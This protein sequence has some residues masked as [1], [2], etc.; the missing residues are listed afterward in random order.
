MAACPCCGQP[1]ETGRLIVGMTGCFVYR[2]GEMARLNPQ[3]AALAHVLNE[4][5]GELVPMRDFYR[6]VYGRAEPPG[7]AYQAISGGI[8]RLRKALVP[9]KAT[10]LSVHAE[11]HRLVLD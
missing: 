3:S 6:A 1:V 4:R 11:G 2:D 7:T 10:V 5:R 9:L 8:S